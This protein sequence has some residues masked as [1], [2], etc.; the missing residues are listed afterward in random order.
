MSEDQKKMA[1][2]KELILYA[3]DEPLLDPLKDWPVCLGALDPVESKKQDIG[4]LPCFIHAFEQQD[5]PESERLFPVKLVSIL[6]TCGLTWFAT[7]PNTPEY[8]LP[9][10]DE[11]EDL[12]LDDVIVPAEGEGSPWYWADFD[13]EDGAGKQ[14]PVRLAYNLGSS[15]ANEGYWGAVWHRETKQKLTDIK[16]TGDCESTITVTPAAKTLYTPHNR[17]LPVEFDQEEFGRMKYQGLRYGSDHE[18]EK[19]SH[20]ALLICEELS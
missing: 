12:Q 14:I 15:D 6:G 8:Q 2:Y 19:L 5:V 16:S 17:F 18:L 9:N 1:L 4:S 13:I 7:G 3:A 10:R 20:M 11:F